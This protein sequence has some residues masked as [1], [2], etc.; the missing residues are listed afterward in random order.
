MTVLTTWKGMLRSTAVLGFLIN[1]AWL[2]PRE[3][4]ITVRQA[5]TQIEAQAS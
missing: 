3:R 4:F 5:L 1:V 2:W